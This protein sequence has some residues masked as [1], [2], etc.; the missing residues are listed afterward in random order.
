VV[1]AVLSAIHN[2]H[3]YLKMME[4]IREAIANNRFLE[5]KSAFLGAY[6]PGD[7]K[8]KQG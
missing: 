4:E 1:S 2:V 7:K 5:Y 3:F 6:L 8:N